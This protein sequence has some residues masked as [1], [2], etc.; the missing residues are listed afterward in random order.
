MESPMIP[1]INEGRIRQVWHKDE[2][3]YSV[4]DIIA[5]LLDTE[6]KKAQ[7]YYHVLKGRL[8]KEGSS[9]PNLKQIK[10]RARDNKYYLT[11]FMN[12]EGLETLTSRIQHNIQKKHVRINIR[13]DDEV[14][15]FHKTVINSLQEEWDIEHHFSLASGAEID[16][17][18]RSKTDFGKILVIE[19][20]PRLARHKFYAA[21]GQVLCYCAEFGQTAKP[22]IATYSSEVTDYVV[23]CCQKM[24]IELLTI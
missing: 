8:K 9:L 19:C 6:Q 4:I 2:W 15:H 13:Q 5:E 11:D 1:Q 14:I 17:L 3:Y 18:A 7:H 23:D 10:T 16:I 21:V 24:N 22:A 20:K 12:K